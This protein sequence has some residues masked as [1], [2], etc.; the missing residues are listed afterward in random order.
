MGPAPP[1]NAGSC[2]SIRIVVALHIGRYAAALHRHRRCVVDSCHECRPPVPSARTFHPWSGRFMRLPSMLPIQV[3]IRQHIRCMFD[4]SYMTALP[5]LP[6]R[7]HKPSRSFAGR[8]TF[9]SHDSLKHLRGPRSFAG[10]RTIILRQRF[11][12]KVSKLPQKTHKP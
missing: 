10:F 7:A 2:R 4:A 12:M 8:L 11:A 9:R 3:T 6:R 5:R 1:A